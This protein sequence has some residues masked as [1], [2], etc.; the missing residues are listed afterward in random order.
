LAALGGE[1][2]YIFHLTRTRVVKIYLKDI[3]CIV[4]KNQK[5]TIYVAGKRNK[6]TD[7]YVQYGSLFKYNKALDAKIF[8]Q[9]DKGLIVNLNAVMRAEDGAILFDRVNKLDVP[10]MCVERVGK[11]MSGARKTIPAKSRKDKAKRNGNAATLKIHPVKYYCEIEILVDNIVYVF[12]FKMKNIIR[13]YDRERNRFIDYQIHATI[14][15]M[16]QKLPS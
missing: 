2:F 16:P 5:K 15:S 3:L 1:D 12:S 9:I 11:L 4:S 13:Y 6:P 7:C 10:E 8:P 14:H